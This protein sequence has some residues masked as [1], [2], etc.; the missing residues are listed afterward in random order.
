MDIEN[1]RQIFNVLGC[2][3]SIEVLLA[4]YMGYDRSD[5]LRDHLSKY[6]LSESAISNT[7]ARLEHAKLIKR[8]YIKTK[9]RKV[10]YNLTELGNLF[11]SFINNLCMKY[12][13]IV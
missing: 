9:P 2:K 4:I 7:L 8:E 13:V 10:K 5:S 11:A 3:H 6:N 1:I 12:G